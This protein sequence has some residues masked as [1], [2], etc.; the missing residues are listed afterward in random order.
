MDQ[1]AELAD[2]LV[3][4][5]P[6]DTE[7][8]FQVFCQE[9][10]KNDSFIVQ[11]FEYILRNYKL[12]W[13]VFEHLKSRIKRLFSISGNTILLFEMEAYMNAHTLN[14]YEA[15]KRYRITEVRK[16]EDYD[17]LIKCFTAL[18]KTQRREVFNRILPDFE[19]LLEGFS[20]SE[21]FH[22]VSTL[23][24][25]GVYYENYMENTYAY[26]VFGTPYVLDSSTICNTIK[27]KIKSFT[28][29]YNSCDILNSEIDFVYRSTATDITGIIKLMQLVDEPP[30]VPEFAKI[31]LFS[32]SS[33]H[34]EFLIEKGYDFSEDPRTLFS[35][36][37]AYCLTGKYAN[38]E[39][40][41]RLLQVLARHRR[42][43]LQLRRL[44]HR[45]EE[46]WYDENPKWKEYLERTRK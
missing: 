22:L 26:P 40:Q 39:D 1:I 44:A 3:V 31:A 6:F 19:K 10:Q 8:R 21:R 15:F 41:K 9:R 11:L 36:I 33:V 46:G 25:P 45:A 35:Y 7:A 2:S 12:E 24:T 27:D 43:F 14:F 37:H 4:R 28:E 29:W 20:A 34:V 38:R 17:F 42:G 16:Y 13:S 32:G 23:V 30:V 18:R 5:E